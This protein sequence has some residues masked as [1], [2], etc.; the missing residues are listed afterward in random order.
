MRTRFLLLIILV[1]LPIAPSVAGLKWADVGVNGLT[2]SMCTRSV[3]MS[4]RR[5]D[6]VD[7]VEMSLEATEGR[8]FFRPDTPLDLNAIARAVVNAGFSVRFLRL[9]MSFEDIAVESDGSFRFQGQF[10]KWIGFSGSEKASVA[11]KLV[12]DNF[13]PKRENAEWKKQIAQSGSGEQKVLYVV[14]QD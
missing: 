6:F 4:L 12:G 2:C 13:L 9:Q 10:F 5:L 3:E 8:I 7:R 14:Q 1:I 11:L